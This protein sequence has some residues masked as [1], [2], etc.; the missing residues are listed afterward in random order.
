MSRLLIIFI[1]E[2]A[3]A[4]ICFLTLQAKDLAR[5][6][7]QRTFLRAHPYVR[8]PFQAAYRQQM[9]SLQ[10]CA[11]PSAFC[12]NLEPLNFVLQHLNQKLKDSLIE[13]LV[14][15]S[16]IPVPEVLVADQM[17]VIERDFLQNLMYSGQALDQYLERQG[18]IK[19][20][21]QAKEL[22][23]AAERR[24]QVGLALSELAKV[25]KIE[26]T[27]QMLEARHADLLKRYD[28]NEQ[29]KKQLDTPEARRDLANRV[30]T[31]KTVD[32]LV[33]LNS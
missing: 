32:R 28:D 31:E 17:A 21:W 11:L 27:K 33:E 4:F 6:G 19:E 14:K 22:R 13:Q 15:A 16:H 2:F 8:A 26:V 9:L 18:Q 10:V 5:Q 25:E 29:I 30:L 24:V 12:K 20:D 1:V 3:I 23:P 7:L